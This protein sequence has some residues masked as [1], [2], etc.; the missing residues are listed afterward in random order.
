MKHIPPVRNFIFSVFLII[1]LNV[2]SQANNIRFEHLPDGLDVTDNYINKIVQDKQGYIWLCSHDGLLKYDGYT[3]TKY[4]YDPFDPSS[5]SQNTVYTLFID[6]NDTMWLGTPEGLTLFDRKSER[7][8]RLTAAILLNIPNLGNVSAINEDSMGNLWIGNFEG[9]L[10]RYTP[11]TGRFLALTSK[12]NIEKKHL[13]SDIISIKKIYTDKKGVVWVGTIAAL[14]RLKANLEKYVDISFTHFQSDSSNTDS[15]RSSNIAD[16]YEDSQ[17][18]LWISTSKPS[19]LSRFDAATQKFINYPDS[20][21]NDSNN[22]WGREILEDSSGT[23]WIADTYTLKSL[24]KERSKFSYWIDK[25]I[26]K[27]AGQKAT[28]IYTFG[29]DVGGNLFISTSKGVHRLIVNQK[30]FGLLQHD[31]LDKN[32]ISSNEVLTLARDREGNIWIGSNNGGLNKWN[33]TAG[34]ITRYQF[35][36]KNEG[37]LKSNNVA[38]ILE[39]MEGNLWIGNGE[40]LSL[41]K[42][43]AQIFEHVNC[44]K[45]ILSICQDRDGLIWMGTDNGIK[46]F[47]PVT[48]KFNHYRKKEDD[49]TSISDFTVL[50]VFADSRGNIWAGTGSIA[51]NKFNK[52]TGGFIHYKN[53][54]LDT[55]SISSNIVQTVFEDSKGNLWI[56]TNGGGLC[57]YNYNT[58]NF[59]THTRYKDLPWST[60]YSIREDDAGNL[61]LG[62]EKGLSCYVT[63]KK[64]FINYDVRDG[65]QSNLFAAGTYLTGSACKGKDGILY[66]GGEQGL[67][68]F[69]PAQI[70]P[71]GYKPPVLITKFKIFDKLQP[72]K[73]EAKEIVLNYKQ[74]FFSFEFTALNYTNPQKNK[75]AYQLEGFDP[76][77]IESGSRRYASY[78][79]LDPGEYTFR[80][81]G[82]NNDGI[83]NEEGTSIRLIIRPPWWKTWWA[84]I[85]YGLLLAAGILFVHRYQKQRVIQAEREKAYAKEMAQAREIEKAYTELKLTQAQLVQ[86]EKMASL[87]E[88]TTGIAHEIQNPLNFVTNFSEI[89]TELIDELK[90]AMAKDNSERNEEI[91]NSLLNGITQN[92]EKILFHGQRVDTIVKSMLL[93]SRKS[94]GQKEPTDIN[95]LADEYLRLA[96][97]GM[98][99]KDKSFDVMV[100]TELDKNI[101]AAYIIPQDIG[102]VVLNLITNAFYTVAEKKKNQ[103]G[104]VPMVTV[105]TKRLNAFANG[106]GRR[107]EI[108]VKDNGMGISD[109]VIDKIFQPF[110]TTKPPGQGAGLGLSLS[111]DI[112]KAHGGELKVETKEGEG[113]EFIIWLPLI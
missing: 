76:D 51:F 74:N 29:L 107:V 113:A 69:D 89:N 109:K 4:K 63:A 19:G 60:V 104:Y 77:W 99:A 10:W 28:R 7:F 86:S 71:N 12:L 36:P 97:H 57:Q 39:D 8:T 61:W 42:K 52:A 67:T 48:K 65:L 35:N 82:S 11:K 45:T 73:N 46:S 16:I 53:N 25:N 85:I 37:G 1:S 26:F 66:F 6:R 18:V 75:Y 47:N 94:T 81:K 59:T 30:A 17:G 70:K 41:L 72:G 44:S 84:Y 49:P 24:N 15:L 50:A 9:Q 68:Y 2:F 102:R 31:P 54:P 108:S 32:S 93:H 14:H 100:K 64:E 96:Y 27:D 111:Y 92:F 110:F 103:P 105:A 40:Y 62:T 87:G 34:T 98:R 101:G 83:W 13:A 79:N 3:V 55:T 5:I 95:K 91:E 43:G 56:G 58:N 106:L 90:T 38:G 78:T 21:A 112:V 88:L 23:L 20:S 33:K 80:I 22:A